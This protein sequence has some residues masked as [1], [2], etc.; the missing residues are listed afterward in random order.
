MFQRLVAWEP[1]VLINRDVSKSVSMEGKPYK[2]KKSEGKL[3]N[4][5]HAGCMDI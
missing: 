2:P 1:P 3:T 4:V 5:H